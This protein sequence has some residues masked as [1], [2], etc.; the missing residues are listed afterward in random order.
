MNMSIYSDNVAETSSFL[1]LDFGTAKIGIAVA[2]EET[3]MAFALQTLP[4]DAEFFSKLKQIVEEKNVRTIVMGTTW[5][6]KDPESAEKKEQ[7]ANDVEKNVGIA[8]MFQD[9]MFTTKMAHA[10]IK[11]RGGKNI[12]ATDDQ[13]AA[14]IILQAWLDRPAHSSSHAS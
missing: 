8:V 6:E 5:H 13:E 10:N 12:A 11:L 4:N 2:D 9:E 14:R 7:F 1:G 3:R